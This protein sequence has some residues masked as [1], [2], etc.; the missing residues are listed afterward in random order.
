M[1]DNRSTPLHDPDLKAKKY[2]RQTLL[3]QG[4]GR[5][6]S[7]T[8]SKSAMKT[9]RENSRRLVTARLYELYDVMA[10]LQARKYGKISESKQGSG[11][12]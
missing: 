11:Q 2:P 9:R 6:S 5:G 1:E 12:C 7:E 4:G 8:R 10:W 3:M